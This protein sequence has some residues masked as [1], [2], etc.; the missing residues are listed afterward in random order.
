MLFNCCDVLNTSDV[1][2]N[3]LSH[4]VPVNFKMF[5]PFMKDWVLGNL[6]DAF[7]DAFDN[8]KNLWVET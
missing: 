7:V 3:L 2:F 6:D 5:G 1:G 4:K 8:N